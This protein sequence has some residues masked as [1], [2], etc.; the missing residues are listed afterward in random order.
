MTCFY[1]NLYPPW[2]GTVSVNM[3]SDNDTMDVERGT[4]PKATEIDDTWLAHCR[5]GDHTIATSSFSLS[6]FSWPASASAAAPVSLSS[7]ASPL[8]WRPNTRGAYLAATMVPSCPTQWVS[9]R[10]L[11]LSL[12]MNVQRSPSVEFTIASWS[13]SGENESLQ[14]CCFPQE[15]EKRYKIAKHDST[16]RSTLFETPGKC[17]SCEE[18]GRYLQN[19]VRMDMLLRFFLILVS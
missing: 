3:V 15:S 6:A 4:E 1:A 17:C 8:G 7:G 13:P 14:A 19:N 2:S 10:Q 18:V 12:S 5:R 16:A 11:C 9:Q